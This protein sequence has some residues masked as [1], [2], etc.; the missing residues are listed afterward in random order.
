MD[1]RQLEYFVTVIEEGN[2][3]KAA[4]RLHLSQPPLSTQIRLL[5]E[6]FGTKLLER[7]PRQVTP[8]DAGRLLYNRAKNIL[9]MT[10]ATLSE[11]KMLAA[12]GTEVLHL[13]TISTTSTIIL[14]PRLKTYHQKN[15]YIRFDIHEGNTSELLGWLNTGTIEIAITRTPVIGE[16]FHCSYLNQPEPMI[17]LLRKE[18]D[19]C[20]NRLRI[21][22][23]EL[24]ARPLIYHRRY[25]RIVEEECNKYGFS[26]FCVSISNVR[27]SVLWAVS[28]IG[29]ALVPQS[30]SFY[31]PGADMTSKILDFPMADSQQCVLWHKHRQLSHSAK[32]FL[33]ILNC[34]KPTA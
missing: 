34:Q 15:P 7:G 1:L 32:T 29:I 5:E 13:G 14:D 12:S 33:S 8:T 17:A 28:G 6:E 20:P 3:T 4:V 11:V 10:D 27:N 24:E 2:I 30:A 23:K 9:S 16:S 21:S 31:A 22:V 25:I 19:W 26:P 18:M